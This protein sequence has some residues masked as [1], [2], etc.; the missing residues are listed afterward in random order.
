MMKFKK[1]PDPAAPEATSGALVNVVAR[2]R[3]ARRAITP[4]RLA[5]KLVTRVLAP[6]IAELA[7]ALVTRDVADLNVEGY[8]TDVKGALYGLTAARR[9]AHGD[10]PLSLADVEAL[11]PPQRATAAHL[12][13]DTRRAILE[14]F[15]EG[16]GADGKPFSLQQ[17]A[18]GF[19]VRATTV[20]RL[21]RITSEGTRGEDPAL[22]AR[23]RAAVARRPSHAPSV[24]SLIA[25]VDAL[26]PADMARL[27]DALN[28]ASRGA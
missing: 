21:V 26:S 15:C 18:T 23:V 3:K 17:I 28:G 19:E 1:T 6:T 8:V 9:E 11:M 2:T 27:R 25:R 16:E 13:V 12:D 24:E 10:A 5:Q 14:S 4:A 20:R 22:V 7:R